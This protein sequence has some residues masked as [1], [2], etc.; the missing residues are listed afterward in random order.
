METATNS[1]EQNM[2]EHTPGPWEPSSGPYIVGATGEGAMFSGGDWNIFP[3]YGESGPVAVVNGGENARLIAAA[4]DLL[5]A[6]EDLISDAELQMN[7]PSHHMPFSLPKARAA[8]AKAT[9]R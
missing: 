7:N 4:P 8:I 5:E 2:S 9:G 1:R 3:P 6:L